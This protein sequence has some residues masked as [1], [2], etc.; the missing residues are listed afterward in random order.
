MLNFF[1][2][3]FSTAHTQIRQLKSILLEQNLRVSIYR[4]ISLET[5]T[6]QGFCKIPGAS[7]ILYKKQFY[8][9]FNKIFY[10]NDSQFQ[11]NIIIIIA[12]QRK[13]M[14]IRIL[15]L[16]VKKIRRK[17]YLHSSFTDFLI[18]HFETPCNFF[19]QYKGKYHLTF[20]GK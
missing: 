19:S 4:K 9:Y 17:N 12:M 6:F 20:T 13:N 2:L 3:V 1:L 14:N 18:L 15:S 7:F 11:E 5:L 16:S 8:F 10:K